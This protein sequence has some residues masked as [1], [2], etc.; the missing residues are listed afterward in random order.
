M[1][2]SFSMEKILVKLNRISSIIEYNWIKIKWSSNLKKQIYNLKFYK[3]SFKLIPKTR[4]FETTVIFFKDLYFCWRFSST[5]L[6]PILFIRILN[7]SKNFEWI[8]GW[9]TVK[10]SWPR[11][12]RKNMH[13][14][15][16]KFSNNRQIN[17]ELTIEHEESNYIRSLNTFVKRSIGKYFI[18]V[19]HKNTLTLSKFDKLN[20][21][22]L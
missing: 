13:S 19:Y 22:Q 9:D 17:I 4:L 7:Y 8:Y 18:T 3:I 15:H 1:D 21:K 5:F 2:W 16:F 10:V 20:I 14:C 12:V 11:L 6:Y